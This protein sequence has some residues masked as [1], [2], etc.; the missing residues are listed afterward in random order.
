MDTDVTTTQMTIMGGLMTLTAL[1]T[2]G[3]ALFRRLCKRHRS[4]QPE[5]SKFEGTAH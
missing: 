3:V 5:T 1:L 2:A 4:E